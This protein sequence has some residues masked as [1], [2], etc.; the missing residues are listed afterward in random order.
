MI[1]FEPEEMDADNIEDAK[2]QYYMKQSFDNLML[3]KILKIIPAEFV[4]DVDQ[5]KPIND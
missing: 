1:Y 3:P 4:Y 2:R 5:E